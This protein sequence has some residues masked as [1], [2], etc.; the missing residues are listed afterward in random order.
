MSV[1]QGYPHYGRGMSPPGRA[2]RSLAEDLRGR[3]DAELAAL[4]LAR[5]DLARP[6]P[7]DLTALAARA[8]TRASTQRAVESLNAGELQVLE[9]LAALGPGTTAKA[10]SA[11]MGGADVRP[12]LAWLHELALVWDAEGGATVSRSA[13]DVL[14]PYPAGLAPSLLSTPGVAAGEPLW[15][16]PALLETLVADAP[17]DAT[18]VLASLT[19]GPPIGTLSRATGRTRGIRWLLDHGLLVSSGG[20]RVV[21]PRNVALALRGGQTHMN[22]AIEPP[23]LDATTVSQRIARAIAGSAASALLASVTELAELWSSDPPR[24]LRSGG[25]PV[26]DLKRTANALDVPVERATFLIE[27]MYAGG[28]LADDGDISPVWALTAAYDDWSD[29]PAAVRWARLVTGWAASARAPFLLSGEPGAPQNVLGPD[30]SWPPIR[31]IRAD[32]LREYA[33]L[34][35]GQAVSAEA[36]VARIAWRRPLRRA[37]P[38]AAAVRAV[39][40]DLSALGLLANGAAVEATLALAHGEGEGELAAAMDADMPQP[41]DH[42]VVQADLTAV[43]PGPL[44]GELAR[45]MRVIT[46]IESRGTATVHRFTE[47]T[48]RRALDTGWTA[49]SIVDAL[50]R[51]SRTPLPQPLTYLIGDAARRHGVTRVGTATAYIR[52]DDPAALEAILADRTLAG[53]GLRRIAP[54]VLVSMAEPSVVLTELRES[55]AAPVL[56]RPDGSV[57][58]LP[59]PPRRSG[60]R[61]PPTVTIQDVDTAYARRLV[62]AL[63]NATPV[64]L[65]I[66]GTPTA[67]PWTEP[68]TTLAILRE[69]IT[70]GRPVWLGYADQQGRAT[71]MLFYPNQIDGGRLTGTPGVD[72]EEK[73]L[74]LHRITGV[75]EE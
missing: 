2:A 6:A 15:D 35:L 53:L 24:V 61:R 37:Q 32:V 16:D 51:W 18:K 13:L 58:T 49:T 10:L 3:S 31:T 36:L 63:R 48:I 20:D 64:Q 29:E 68:G 65:P 25:L 73:V 59:A 30:L 21:L 27:L 4:L 7:A 23:E 12:A 55:G 67:L 11:A 43:A 54:T 44:E 56:E 5:P 22:P 52:S 1:A 14:G 69:A 45:F 41:V 57:A 75:A 70:D 26:K 17:A 9:A 42:I 60:R 34:G 71:R 38:G 46:D 40:E 50:A 33:G 47:A 66:E 62:T 28:L 74:W 72:A 39:L 19:W 8:S